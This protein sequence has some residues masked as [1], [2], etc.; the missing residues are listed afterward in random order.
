MRENGFD[1][2]ERS[3]TPIIR[4]NK[5]V[6][7]VVIVVW[8]LG[9]LA[10][11][12]AIQWLLPYG[13]QYASKQEPQTAL[14]TMQILV[15]FLFLSVLPLGVYLFWFGYRAVQWRQIPP[16]GPWVIRNTKVVEGDPAQRR[17]RIIVALGMLL[18]ALG[19]SCA[20][21]FSYRLERVFHGRP[22]QP[23]AESTKPDSP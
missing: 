2:Q 7:L 11:A 9:A 3:S 18:F 14:R 15:A 8:I 10:A 17:G 19:S 12:A 5:K 6:R 23:S 4:A 20:I 1:A 16:P 21:Y 13:A 22:S